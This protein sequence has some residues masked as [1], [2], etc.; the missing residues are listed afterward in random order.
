MFL[1]R[2]LMLVSIPFYITI[3]IS[4]DHLTSKKLVKHIAFGF[5]LMAFILTTKPNYSNDRN[6]KE[7]VEK[8]IEL[9]NKNTLVYIKPDY[10]DFNFTYYYDMSCFKNYN[11][12]DIKANI[13]KCLKDDNVIPILYSNEISSSFYKSFNK[14]IFLDSS[15]ETNPNKN[16][17]LKK[18]NDNLILKSKYHFNEIFD[19][20]EFVNTKVEN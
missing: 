10:L 8:V 5:L 9:K 15:N 19:V 7:A 13:R 4:I 20:Y 11:T 16:E 18:L 2:Y 3:G 6:I 17:S 1:A 12:S 14:V